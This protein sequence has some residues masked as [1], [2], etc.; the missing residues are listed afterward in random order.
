[1]AWKNKHTIVR[2]SIAP[3][4]DVP[5]ISISIIWNM[6]WVIVSISLNRAW[7]TPIA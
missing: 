7:S 2:S 3:M 4:K 5:A 6:R 1:M